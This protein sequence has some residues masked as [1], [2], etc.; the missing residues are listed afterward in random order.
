MRTGKTLIQ[1]MALSRA[2]KEG[3]TCFV[4]GLKEPQ[5][6]ITRLRK[7]H[8]VSVTANPHYKE[9]EITG[10]SFKLK[11]EPLNEDQLLW[12]KMRRKQYGQ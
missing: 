9:A 3:K 5:E 7:D 6:Y 4:A 8:G 10:Y 12:A 2:L 11:E 1:F